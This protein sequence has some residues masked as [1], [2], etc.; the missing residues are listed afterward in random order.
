EDKINTSTLPL[1]GNN[2]LLKL[3]F[4]DKIA[5]LPGLYLIRLNARDPYY[6]NAQTVVCRS[7]IGLIAKSGKRDISIFANSIKTAQALAGVQIKL[8]GRNN[9]EVAQLTTDESGYASYR[10]PEDQADGFRVSLV[11][12]S[13]NDDFTYL[14]FNRTRIGTS[15]FEVEGRRENASGLEVF[16]YGERD[17]YRPGETIHLAAVARDYQWQVPQSG[18]LKLKLLSPDGRVFTSLRKTPNAEGALEAEI[19]VPVSAQT[20]RYTAQLWSASDVLLASMGIMVEE[21]IPD[22]IKVDLNLDRESYELSQPIQVDA[23]A[24]NFF[25]PPAAGRNYEV[26]LSLSRRYFRSEAHPEYNFHIPNLSNSFG[27]ERRNGKTDDSGQV[28]ES[29]TLSS[30][31]ANTGL[32][33]ADIFTA[34]FDE[35]G[36]PVNRRKTAKIYTQDIFLGTR[37]NSYYNRTGQ[38]VEIPL[39]AVDKSG[40]SMKGVEVRVRLIKKEYKTVMARSGSYFRYQSEPHDVIV[41]DKQVTLN[42]TD[43]VFKFTPELTGRYELRV[44]R[45]GINSYVLSGFYAYGYGRTSNQSFQVNRQGRIDI[46]LDKEEYA[47]GESAKVLVKTPF[48]GQLL[49]TVETDKVLKHYRMDTDKRTA[50]LELPL[51]DTHVPNIYVTATLFK[52]HGPS[53]MP[54]TSAHG[55]APIIVN[56]K[57]NQLP[58]TITAASES[59]SKTKQTIKI[60]SEP[61]TTLTV[62]VVDEGI[63]Q[64]TN[65]K[66]PDPYGFFYAKR[67][68]EVGTFDVYPYLY[69]ELN[70]GVSSPGGDGMDLARRINP[71][72]NNRVKL[73]S[74]WSGILKTNS[75]GEAEYEVDIPQFSGS[76]RV[77]VSAFKGKAFAA[78]EQNIT[79]ADPLVISM[80]MPRFFSPGDT[81]DVSVTLTNTTKNASAMQ[82]QLSAE[83]PIK[84]VSSSSQNA[85]LAANKEQRITYRVVAD[86]AIG[87]AS[88]KLKAD[89]LGETFTQDMDI[90]VRPPSTLQKRSG[91][92]KITVGQTATAKPD[93]EAFL[94]ESIHLKLVVSKSPLVEFTDQLERLLVSR[95][96][97]VDH[98]VSRAFPQLY[99]G[100][101]AEV[102]YRNNDQNPNPGYH[103]QE[104]IKRLQLMQL[105]NGGLTY[106]PQSGYESWWGS[107]YAA[108]FLHE[109][110]R[111]GYAIPNDMMESLQ[112]YM[113]NQLKEVKVRPYYYNGTKKRS[114]YPQSVSYSLFV[115]ALTGKPQRST[116]N[117]YKSR[118]DQLNLTSKYLLAAA[119]AV[120]GDRNAYKQILPSAFNGEKADPTF[121]DEFL[122]HVRDEALALYILQIVSPDDPQI[123]TMAKHVSE[124]LRDRLWMNTQERAFSFLSL[125]K[126][127]EEAAKTNAKATVLFDGKTVGTFTDKPL[128]LT[129]D[130]PAQGTYQIKTEGTGTLY[131]FWETEGIAVDGSYVEEDSY[132]KIRKSFYDRDGRSINPM[133]IKQNDL[134]VVKLD[135][136]G[137]SQS[138]VDNIAV[139]DILPAGLEIEN[140][141]ISTLPN[142]DWMKDR[143]AY[144]YMDVRDDRIIFFTNLYGTR[145][146]SFYYLARAVSPGSFKMGPASA[147]ALYQGEYHSYHGGGQVRILPTQ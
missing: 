110:K 39:I 14:P 89:A 8:V 72:V 83:G 10:L 125:G 27:Q 73:A 108:H 35:T 90:T 128:E 88:L 77:M 69:P 130:Q 92:G 138:R 74:F 103:V 59:R 31:Y 105:R 127:A 82:A 48:E 147:D 11:T 131:Y 75:R 85:R 21:F 80:G 100:D 36:R 41:V 5:D 71:L 122:S 4:E 101:I 94:P 106:W 54:L 51:T 60:K 116:M 117:Y 42:G 146:C 57:K 33:E 93:F 113:I 120:I 141:R 123:P 37:R 50:L 45:P 111:A 143:C 12:A 109:A 26:E 98:T 24:E 13:Q 124:N 7:D 32:M 134:V 46:E 137:L 97:S 58:I 87:Q 44:S 3:D 84:V 114:I 104:A 145:K 64:L 78:K 70:L 18:P 62:S 79:V 76:L 22:R 102:I 6:L 19:S 15:R 96:Y 115:L 129:T 68:L 20:G 119:Y 25:G 121:G 61:N 132:L 136:E 23:K 43:Y 144:Q 2:R 9:Q 118:L 67:A 133:N 66:T 99:Y 49:L 34:V 17:I 47:V 139:T 38:Q 40:K 30:A 16:L 65:F 81:V 52:P 107:I 86:Y 135:L 140:P 55:F 29:F 1:N 91:A 112:D 28:K 95:Y 142:I 63:L 126:I 53:D 56:Q